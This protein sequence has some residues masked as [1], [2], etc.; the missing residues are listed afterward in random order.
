MSEDQIF[1]ISYQIFCKHTELYILFFR[2]FYS[3]K[4][5]EVCYFPDIQSGFSEAQFYCCCF[6]TILW[7]K[8]N[9]YLQSF[10][11][12]FQE[13]LTRGIM[14]YWSK[15]LSVMDC[16]E[17]VWD[18]CLKPKLSLKKY[19]QHCS[20]NGIVRSGHWRSR[21]TRFFS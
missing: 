21:I 2:V 14:S 16:L 1:W 3:C 11:L 17:I 12:I 10:L 19:V 5:S 6:F 20:A 18:D 8:S 4:L 7:T 13:F 9:T 15:D